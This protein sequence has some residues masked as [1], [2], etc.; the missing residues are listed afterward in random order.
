MENLRD[1][2]QGKERKA[3][4]DTTS[5]AQ[6]IFGDW[7]KKVVSPSEKPRR[8]KKKAK[9][10]VEDVKKGALRGI[11]RLVERRRRKRRITSLDALGGFEARFF[12]RGRQPRKKRSV[13]KNR[14]SKKCA[15]WRGKRKERKETL[16]RSSL[17]RHR[18]DLIFWH[19]SRGRT[20]SG[21]KGVV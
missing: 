7:G 15:G 1:T 16:R 6:A 5:A 11:S 2:G 21:E 18:Q 13:Q 19:R 8:Q 3:C 9:N 10:V 4:R 17:I 14:H 12:T 20:R